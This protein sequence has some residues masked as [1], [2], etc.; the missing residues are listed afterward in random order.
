MRNAR[1]I[2]FDFF[3]AT[4]VAVLGNIVAS[5]LQERFSLTHPVRFLFVAVL[6]AVCLILL[7]LA[8]LRRS[9]AEMADPDG[10]RAPIGARVRQVIKRIGREGEVVGVEAEE[11]PP[12]IPT[13]VEQ[14]AEKVAGKMTGVR[15]GRSSEA[16]SDTQGE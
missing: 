16:C 6:F 5:Y 15:I 8:T 9:H 2:V 13:S 3:L 1:W 11:F 12:S 4:I 14:E 7:L 10:D